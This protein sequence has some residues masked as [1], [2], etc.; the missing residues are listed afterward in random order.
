MKSLL[1]GFIPKL[2]Q[3]SEEMHFVPGKIEEVV[4]R[5]YFLYS[6]MFLTFKAELKTPAI[7]QYIHYFE[8]TT[9]PICTISLRPVLSSILQN[10]DQISEKRKKL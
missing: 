6:F 5:I 2:S 3:F 4:Y 9:L 7:S 8:P 1:A 10:S